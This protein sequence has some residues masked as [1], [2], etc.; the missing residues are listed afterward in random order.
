MAKLPPTRDGYEDHLELAA[1][2]CDPVGLTSSCRSP[3]L[4]PEGR[5]EARE[6]ILESLV[7]VPA[8]SLTTGCWMRLS[9]SPLP[10]CFQDSFTG[11]QAK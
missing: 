7:L 9:A 3:C 5:Q 6:I 8:L 4:V 1:E 10:L 11:D 2:T